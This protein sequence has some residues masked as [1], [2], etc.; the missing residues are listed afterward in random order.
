M[1]SSLIPPRAVSW[2][3]L[4]A[5]VVALCMAW[6]AQYGF[7]FLPCELCLWQRYGYGLAIVL[8]LGTSLSNPSFRP[9][10]LGLLALSLAGVAAIAFFHVGVEHSW[11]EGT[12]SCGTRTV[13]NSVEEITQAI[14]NA[15][16][17]RCDQASFLLFGFSMAFYNM[18][19]ALGLALFAL[20]GALKK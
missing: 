19:Y 7:G 16:L 8:A 3:I 4:A 2:L 5:S 13:G 1:N 9:L 12:S 14:E 17:A 15:P 10:G 18:L 6:L 11:W 20:W